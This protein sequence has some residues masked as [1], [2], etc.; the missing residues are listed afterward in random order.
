[1]GGR[2]VDGRRAAHPGARDARPETSPSRRESASSDFADAMSALASGVVLVTTCWHGQAVGHDRHG[3]RVGLR[4]PADRARVARLRDDQRARDRSARDG[5]GVSILAAD[6]CAVARYGS[7]QRTAAKFLE[8]VSSTQSGPPDAEP[9]RRRARSPTSTA[10]SPKRVESRTTPSS[11]A[12]CRSAVA[13]PQGD[14]LRLLHGRA[15]R[16][17]AE[18]SAAPTDRKEHVD[19]SRADSPDRTAGA[20]L[21]RARRDARARDR[22]ARRRPRPRRAPSRSTASPPS[23]AAATSRRRSRRSS[24]ASASR[25]STTSWSRS[26]RLA[27]GDA[28]LT[29]GVNMHLA[30]LLERRAPLADRRRLRRRATRRRASAPRSSRSPATAPSSP[31]PAASSGRTSPGRRRPRRAPRTAGRV[32][33][34]KV[35]CTMSPAAD[36]LYTAVTYADDGGR[37]RYGYAHG[38]ARDAGRRRPRRL[39]RAR[40]ARLGQPLGLVRER[41]APAPRRCAEASRSATPSST[42]TGI[43]APASSTRPRR[44]GVAEA[45]R[46]R[47][48]AA[49]WAGR[50]DLDPRTQ[51]LAA[52]N[53]VD[54]S[55][56]RA[57][58]SRAAALIDEHQAR[59]PTSHAPGGGAD[60]PVR[61]GAEREGLRRPRPQSASSTGRSR[62]PAEPAT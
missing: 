4:R 50:G 46:R 6:Q 48:H 16:T 10:S 36:V 32:S 37:E 40:H 15:Y 59:H 22:P 43:S 41:A 51:M 24:A 44:S 38:P 29:L 39:G 31:P 47:R 33:G 35:F 27:R 1:M 45:R 7:A 54:L 19:A 9:S 2:R 30:Y 17:L 20:R 8:R 62:S 56:C 55:A 53:V 57:V 60:E 34:R 52:E 25:P 61:R 58:L 11:S 3:V 14:P 49:G 28:S 23:R 12:A 26:S 5:F 13:A 18:P 42:W 21:G